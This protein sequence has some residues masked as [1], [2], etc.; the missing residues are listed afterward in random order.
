[1]STRTERSAND[2][3][4]TAAPSGARSDLTTNL[5]SG[6][7]V[8]LIALPLCLGIA[9]ASG[10]PP[11]AGV[12]TAIIGGLVGWLLG[13]APLTIKGPAAGLIVIAIGAVT[14]LGGGEVGYRRALAVGFVAAILQ[15]AFALG[16]LTKYAAVAPPSVV[17]GM[18]A[19][20]GVIIFAK[21]THM[22]MGIKPPGKKPFELLAEIPRSLAHDNVERRLAVGGELFGD[23]TF[24]PLN[25]HTEAYVAQTLRTW[26]H[27]I[28]RRGMPCHPARDDPR[29]AAERLRKR[30]FS[31]FARPSR[32]DEWVSK[33]TSSKTTSIIGDRTRVHPKCSRGGR[34]RAVRDEP[35]SRS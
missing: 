26:A 7:L 4:T 15:I 32:E 17:H 16:K 35:R 14:D 8:S 18:L 22:L 10:F 28:S 31:W 25:L 1:M 6:F 3:A 27:A 30:R 21:Q 9:I 24:G 13:S 20:I 19:A 11:V 12:L 23:L 5:T 34:E 2:R 33:T 29:R